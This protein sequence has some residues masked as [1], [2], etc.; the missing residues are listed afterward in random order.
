M[1]AE[2][3]ELC[4][5]FGSEEEEH[6]ILDVTVTIAFRVRVILGSNSNRVYAVA[7][8]VQAYNSDVRLIVVAL[9]A[10]SA[11]YSS[12]RRNIIDIY[13]ERKERKEEGGEKDT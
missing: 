11:F 9:V 3:K 1:H 2:N 5:L 8:S 13:R 4:I 12:K 10:L 7:F 6:Q